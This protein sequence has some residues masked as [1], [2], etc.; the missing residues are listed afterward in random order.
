[1]PLQALALAFAR[2]GTGR[3]MPEA[4]ANAAKRLRAACAAEPWY[5]AGSGRFCS[6]AMQRF[7]DRV[8]VKPGAEG[9][10]CAALPREGLGI[11]VK[12]DD[13]SGRAAEVVIAALL[14]R[15]A[16]LETTQADALQ[17]FVRPPLRNWGDAVVGELRPAPA[18]E[19]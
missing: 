14:A 8:F 3:A 9:M 15:F 19:G 16:D 1:M 10:F 13:G 12:C 11:A 2:F 18:L 4:R 17:R 7:G 5:V 6:V